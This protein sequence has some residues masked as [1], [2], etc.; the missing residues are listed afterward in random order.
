MNEFVNKLE[1]KYFTMDNHSVILFSLS[2]LK[3]QINK[4]HC[5]CME[6]QEK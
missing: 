3:S 6:V 1:M 5:C 4:D 2:M